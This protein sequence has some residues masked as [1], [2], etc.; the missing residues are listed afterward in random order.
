MP[1]PTAFQRSILECSAQPCP[2]ATQGVSARRYPVSCAQ[3]QPRRIRS[4]QKFGALASLLGCLIWIAVATSAGLA[5]DDHPDP[6]ASAHWAFQLPQRPSLPEADD[7]SASPIDRLLAATYDEQQLTPAPL[8]SSAIR[9]RR[10]YLD[11]IGLPPTPEELR[12]FLA[13]DSQAAYQRIVD[14]LLD[15]PQYGERWARHWMDVWRYSDWHGRRHVPDVWNSAPQ[16]WRWRDWIVRSLNNDKGYD[17]MIVEMLAGDEVA[18]LDPETVVA[19]GYLIR[20]WYALNPNDWM[21]SNVEH[22]GK[23]FLGLTFNCAHCHDHMYDPISQEEY[24]AMRAFFEPIDVRQDRVPG[25]ADP[26]PF[27]E[28]DYSTLRKVQ[29]LGLVRI[30][31]RNPEASTWFYTG[32]DERNRVVERGTI[33]PR[34]PDVF[35]DLPRPIEPVEFP[36]EAWYPGCRVDIQTA[37]LSDVRG[38][39]AAAEQRLA[40]QQANSSDASPATRWALRAAEA[41]VAA[42]QARVQ[43][44]EARIAADR[45][46]YREADATTDAI[47]QAAFKAAAAEKIAAIR[48]AEAEVCDAEVLLVK[49]EAVPV[50][51]AER[52]GKIQEGAAKRQ[53]ARERVDELFEA[54]AEKGMGDAYSPLSPVYPRQSTGRRRALAQWIASRENPLTARVAVNHIW[55]RHFHQPLVKTVFD[56]GQSGAEPTHPALLD[57]LAVELMESGWRQ[58]HLHRLIVTSLAYQRKSSFDPDAPEG[59]R[60]REIDPDNQ[61]LARQNPGRMEAEVVRDAILYCAGKLD[62][63]RGGQEL[64]NSEALTTYRRSLY[65]SCHPE[66]DGKSELGRLFDAPEP[67]ECYRRTRSIVP[68]QALA[69][70]NSA[71]V[72]ELSPQISAR[73]QSEGGQTSDDGPSRD[74]ATTVDA[75]FLRVLSRPPTSAEQEACLSFLAGSDRSQ[76]SE[77]D[78]EDLS[79]LVRVLLNHN[80]FITIR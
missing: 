77:A 50:E 41:H 28:Y 66:T 56:F 42:A 71:L 40:E 22:T 37:A 76:K 17:Q 7:E 25:E 67:R 24:F 64:E 15:S 12:S 18:P 65:Y 31:D 49:A 14:Q 38:E 52:A 2:G 63:T 1:G 74:P 53:A 4:I 62:L 44:V 11:L 10:V 43:S 35:G 19:T 59:R 39:V 68:Q 3:V 34:V 80:D 32:G 33:A 16:I 48:T 6:A 23:A 36:A 8:A 5:A 26:G 57:W 45:Q 60:A 9:L 61:Y 20:N 54:L 72:H 75:A 47:Q 55:T 58:K 46:K 79:G 78:V 27:Q 29:R 73:L 70:S 69:L 21:R 30:Y 13:D 51:N